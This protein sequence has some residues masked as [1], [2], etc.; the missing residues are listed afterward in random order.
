MN[1]KKFLGAASA[2]LHFG[3]IDLN[4]QNK[5]AVLAALASAL[6]SNTGPIWD[7]LL[8]HCHHS[9][10]RLEQ[11]H[12]KLRQE[13]NAVLVVTGDLTAYGAESQFDTAAE[14]LGG[15]LRPPKVASPISD[16]MNFVTSFVT[17][18]PKTAHFRLLRTSGNR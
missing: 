12:A 2:A 9:L 3:D 14:F 6:A 13:E 10:V 1:Y 17:T 5:D 4:S 7:G 16:A 11:I 8:G 15:F 18:S